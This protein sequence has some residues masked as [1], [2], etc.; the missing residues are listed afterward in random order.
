MKKPMHHP[1]LSGERICIRALE[2][3]DLDGNYLQWLNDYEVTKYLESGIFPNNMEAME[4]YFERIDQSPNDVMF[5]IIE[6]DNNKHIGNIK[7]GNINWVSR[8]A[9]IGF[10]VGEKESWGKGY[11]SEAVKLA[12][13]YCFN[14]LN[15]QKII[16]GVVSINL[17]SIRICEKLGFSLEGTIRRWKYIDGE[18]YDALYFGLLGEEYQY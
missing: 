1:F 2:R 8:T 3:A 13:D 17:A 5:A 6:K 11:G 4:R 7:I 16:I 18:Y 10:L 12:V 9:D 14:R 15:L